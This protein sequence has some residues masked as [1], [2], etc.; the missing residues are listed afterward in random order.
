[1]RSLTR[2]SEIDP[3]NVRARRHQPA[4]SAVAKPQHAGDHPVFSALEH[5]GALCFGNERLDLFLTDR[6][7]PVCLLSEQPQHHLRGHIQ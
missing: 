4:Y 6:A 1:M 3:V 5:A 2:L 7:L